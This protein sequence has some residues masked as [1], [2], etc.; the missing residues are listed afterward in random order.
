DMLSVMVAVDRAGRDNGCLQVLKGSHR[1]GRVE[2][3]RFGDQVGADP[4]RVV[5]A[6]K[7]CELVHVE[8][9]PGDTLFFHSNLLH[10]SAANLSDRPRWSLIM[11]YNSRHNDPYCESHHPRYT[12]LAKVPDT[13]IKAWAADPQRDARAKSGNAQIARTAIP[14]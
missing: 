1:M 6:R 11:A 3:G 2:H 9:D 13:A 12:P 10:A 8:S 4:A 5:E 7:V 14:S